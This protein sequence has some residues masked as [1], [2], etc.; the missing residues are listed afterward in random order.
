MEEEKK[1]T[2][3]KLSNRLK[4]K[5]PESS[6]SK[7][8]LESVNSKK[9]SDKSKKDSE[10]LKKESKVALKESKAALK[11]SKVSIKESKSSLKSSKPKEPNEEKKFLKFK[12]ATSS[13][14]SHQKDKLNRSSSET[15]FD[16]SKPNIASMNADDS[17]MYGVDRVICFWNYVKQSMNK[18]DT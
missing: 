11:E 4:Y 2:S 5:K 18:K 1:S 13:A 17:L 6:S 15:I 9:E 8:S 10:K 7:V 16:R 12:K 14:T 3:S